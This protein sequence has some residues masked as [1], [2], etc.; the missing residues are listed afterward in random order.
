MARPSP[1][2]V[3]FVVVAHND[4]ATIDVALTDC[5]S[6][7]HAPT[8]QVIVVNDGSDD[9]TWSRIVEFKSRR[10]EVG[11]L[12]LA[13]RC[14]FAAAAAEGA[15]RASHELVC[16]LG[17]GAPIDAAVA[18]TLLDPLGDPAV[19]STT[20]RRRADGSIEALSQDGPVTMETLERSPSAHR[21]G[22]LAGSTSPATRSAGQH[23]QWLP[24]RV[25][26]QGRAGRRGTRPSI[27]RL[28]PT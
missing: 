27:S 11:A 23:M 10:P 26:I 1:T 25:R 5:S 14:G 2:S 18:N 15:R 17:A 28:R 24:P 6:L 8:Q 22:A 13:Q 4:E 16:V 19:R 9:S 7:A 3:S 20:V 21:R 12:D